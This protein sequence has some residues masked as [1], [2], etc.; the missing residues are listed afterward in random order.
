MD[1]KIIVDGVLAS[2]YAFANHDMAHTGMTP[3]GWFPEIIEWILARAMNPQF[4]LMLQ[5]T[6]SDCCS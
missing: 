6:A 4:I 5:L 2:C 1:G 3:I